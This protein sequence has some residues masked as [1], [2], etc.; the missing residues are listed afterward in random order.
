MSFVGEI[1]NALGRLGSY[2]AIAGWIERLHARPAF[3]ASV[4]KGG[5]YAFA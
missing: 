3:A 5:A 4:E 2:P 1:A